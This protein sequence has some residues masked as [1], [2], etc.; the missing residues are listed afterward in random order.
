MKKN[1]TND[2]VEL[3]IIHEILYISNPSCDF[4]KQRSMSYDKKYLIN[5]V[6]IL[7]SPSIVKV[8]YCFTKWD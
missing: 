7:F 8:C 6:H 5:D 2:F 4:E 1:T 3:K